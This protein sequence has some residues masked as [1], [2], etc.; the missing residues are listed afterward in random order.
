[1]FWKIALG[2][3]ILGVILGIIIFIVSYRTLTAT[4]DPNTEDIAL[5][6]IIAGILLVILSVLLALISIIFVLRSSKKEFDAKT[7]K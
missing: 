7:A 6:G 5:T 2:L 3:G 1:M 4:N